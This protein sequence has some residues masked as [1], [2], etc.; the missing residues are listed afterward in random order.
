[1]EREQLGALIAERDAFNDVAL[2]LV[3]GAD[4]R[5][6]VRA[7]DR[8]LAPFGG[9]GAHGRGGLA[10]HTMLEEHLRPLESLAMIVP[11]A[12]LLV[13][14][15]LV[16]IVLSRS[17]AAQREQ[18]GMLKA[19]GYSNARIAVHYLEFPLL[20]VGAGTA[21]AFPVGNWLGLLIA[22]FFGTFFRFPVLVF[23]LDPEVALAAGGIA[24]AAAAAGTL[25]ALRRVVGLP[26]VVAMSAEVP[27]FRRGVLD[28]VGFSRVLSPASRIV[29]RN[30]G[31][32][33]LRT[34]LGA[35]GMSLAVAVVVMGSGSADGLFRMKD[36]W[37]ERAQRVMS[38]TL[39][40]RR[41]GWG[42]A[43]V[44]AV[45]GIGWALRP[46][47]LHLEL[48]A[49]T[50]GTVAEEVRGDGRTRVRQLYVISTPV[51][52]ELERIA[53]RAG[54]GVEAGQSVA[55]V[56][57]AASRPLDSR[58]RADARGAVEAARG[59]VA[60]A[61]ARE[62]EARTALEHA[63]SKL[64]EARAL[65]DGG[66][67][68]VK[69]VE[70]LEHEVAAR[71]RALE[72]ARAATHQARAQV[73]RALSALGSGERRDRPPATG[74]LAPVSGR[75]LRVLRESAGVVAAGTPLLE[76]GD[77]GGL[78][79][80]AELLSSDAAQVRAGAAARITG[81]GG[82]QLAARVRAVEPVAFTKVS[83]LG[84]EE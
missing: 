20:I 32:R 37:Y 9:R 41:W 54:D 65:A 70:H 16:H 35:A 15:F 26:P 62:E 18:I 38:R 55:Q 27:A 22:R 50:R 56:W 57:P 12:F 36:V 81:W 77:V 53:V 60:G 74:V 71:G 43:A 28:R 72:A 79:V 44:L 67:I 61:E 11:T 63:R 13:A 34:A 75:V 69:D 21:L 52:G 80:I 4:E 25:G 3:P 64:E 2:R 66:A 83:A 6:V 42:I 23:R 51:D 17:I 40:I 82:P 8:I 48:V 1:M 31:R 45:S 19:F 49:V 58:T 10:S 39:R 84:L 29:L 14:A 46:A 68:P 30:L 59:A 7:V 5:A 78:E 76:I 24:L 33:P 47:P 73:A